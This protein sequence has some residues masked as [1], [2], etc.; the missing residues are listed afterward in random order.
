MLR[1][2][3]AAVLVVGLALPYGCDV[4]PVAVLWGGG[5]GPA[6]SLFVAVPVLLVLAYALHAFVP[7][8]ARFHER[9][10]PALHGLFRAVYFMLAGGLLF[11]SLSDE[12]DAWPVWGAALV[13]T[14]A[15]LYW[16]QQRGTKAARLP[17][18][19]LTIV[20]LATV[21][22]FGSLVDTGDLRVGGW[23]LTAGWLGAVVEEVRRLRGAQKVTHGG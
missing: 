1:K 23:V 16:Q 8:I 3:A 19:L 12:P 17:L 13:A 15:L 20:G 4:R 10:G 2:L 18:L 6:T 22:Y 11:M 5:D 14:M 9:N 21:F 7:V